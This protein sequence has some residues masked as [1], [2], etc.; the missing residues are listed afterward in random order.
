LFAPDGDA[1]D[2]ECAWTR[3]YLGDGVPKPTCC[4][5]GNF[6][7]YQCQAGFC[8]CVDRYGRQ[9]G[10]EEDQLDIDQLNCDVD[11]CL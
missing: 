4:D 10:K 5:N 11:H 6:K 1:M 7:E 8:Y 9:V 3:R 2:C